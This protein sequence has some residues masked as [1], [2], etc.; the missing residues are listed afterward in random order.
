MLT[1]AGMAVML[2][3]A[4]AGLLVVAN[5]FGG[6]PADTI[7]VTID[8]TYAGQGVV[9]GTAVV[10]HGV[11]VGEVTAI[12]SRPGGGVRLDADLQR[13]PVVGLT[14]ALRIDFRPVNYF[15]VTG[16]NLMAGAGG[17]VLRDGMRLTTVPEG[18]FTLQALLSRLGEV[19]TGVLTPQLIQVIDRATRYTDALDPLIE[20]AL[21]AADSVAQVQTV[22]TERLLANATG[23]SVVFP[24]AV[25]ALMGAGHNLIHDD[26]NIQGRMHSDYTEEEWQHL[27]IPTLELASGGLFA[28]IGKLESSHLGQLLPVTDMVKALTDV[29]PPLIRPEGFAEMLAELRT[30]F[31]RMYGGTPE[32]R[33]VQIQIVLDSL[34]GVAAPLDAM[35]GP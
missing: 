15:G 27:F 24:P 29:V 35:G 6:R 8:T 30:R 14:D 34:P 28:D 23:V 5:P 11:T 26:A 2:C 25:D 13:K 16:V 22:S 31:E 18:N 7:S 1:A 21:I 12:T 9:R 33:T 17:Q 3:A 10:M 32:Q 4:V 20:T 19:S